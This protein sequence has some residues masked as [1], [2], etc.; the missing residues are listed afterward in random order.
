M[1]EKYFPK[2]GWVKRNRVIINDVLNDDRTGFPFFCSHIIPYNNFEYLYFSS[3]DFESV[4]FCVQ[5]NQ[6]GVNYLKVLDGGP[7][8]DFAFK[9]FKD[10]YGEDTD[11]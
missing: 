11:G 5:V 1:E 8:Q 3:F 4:M 9:L 6:D 2:Q 7:E 10:R